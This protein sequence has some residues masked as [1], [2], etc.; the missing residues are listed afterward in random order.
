MNVQLKGHEHLTDL[1][2]QWYLHIRARDRENSLDFKA[3]IKE[4]LKEIQSDQK[5]LFYYSLLDFRCSYLINNLT[6]SKSS[7]DKI[8]T[9]ATPQEDFL[10]YY[11]HF[12]K[13]IHSKAIGKYTLAENHYE[14]AE[15]LLV[16]IPDELEKAE[17]YYNLAVFHY[18]IYQ[19][20]LAT[21][22][23]AIAKEIF[24]KHT[25]CELKIAYCD[26]LLGLACTHLKEYKLAEEYFISAIDLFRK[27]GNERDI[28]IA[29]QNIGL[30][31][32][33][34]KQSRLAIKYLSEVSQKMPENYKALLVEAKQR[35]NLGEKEIALDLIKK[36]LQISDKLGL[37]EY[38][39]RFRI[40][41]KICNTYSTEDLEKEILAGM[42]YFKEENLWEYMQEYSELL[43]VRFHAAGKFEKASAFFFLSYEAK[44]KI[45]DKEVLK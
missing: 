43:A 28:L 27:F 12:F 24:L 1:L 25:D 21:K 20:L 40:I 16:H 33:E 17:F 44:E 7:F 3:R 38:Q 19:A 29:R 18:H 15:S 11:Y 35:I 34:Q 42:N 22:Y 37:T 13:A 23:V 41:K 36:G 6:I 30:M 45:F 10:A 14:I 9:L 26:N 8:E 5:L 32:A 39:Y 2:N 4:H 31:Y